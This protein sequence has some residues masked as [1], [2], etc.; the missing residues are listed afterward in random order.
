MMKRV[1]LAQQRE[2]LR[3]DESR[4][5]ACSCRWC[6][7]LTNARGLAPHQRGDMC[8]GFKKRALGTHRARRLGLEP[9]RG[10]T[11]PWMRARYMGGE[12][13]VP[14]YVLTAIR[15]VARAFPALLVRSARLHVVTGQTVRRDRVA[16]LTYLRIRRSRPVRD[17][18]ESVNLLGDPD[19]LATFLLEHVPGAAVEMGS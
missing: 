16:Q 18:M 1:S 5:G 3:R 15:I 12:F 17:A 7:T 11:T 6:H 19:Q 8:K 14:R 10:N 9:Y 13:W 4:D 2:D